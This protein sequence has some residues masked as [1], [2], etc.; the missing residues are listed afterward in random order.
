MSTHWIEYIY[1]PGVSVPWCPNCEKEHRRVTSEWTEDALD[2]ARET[3]LDLRQIKIE[4]GNWA[5]MLTLKEQNERMKERLAELKRLV[6]EYTSKDH[7]VVMQL[8]REQLGL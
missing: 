2:E 1:A 7:E 4:E 3:T 5:Q 6:K 8:M